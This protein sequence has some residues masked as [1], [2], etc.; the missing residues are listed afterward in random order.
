[1]RWNK[2]G[3]VFGPE[4]VH[5]QGPTV[6]V[7]EKCLRIYFATR[8]RANESI[9]I[10]LDADINDPTKILAVHDSPLLQLGERGSFDEFGIIPCAV[11]PNG[12]EIWMYYTGWSRG[13][14]VT[15]LLSVGLAVSRDEGRTFSKAYPGP[16]LDRTKVEP[17]MTM[18]PFV[19]REGP[20]W[21]MW[22]GS[23]IGFRE[24]EGKYEPQ[25]VI[26]YAGSE[27]GVEWQRPDLT[28]LV[29]KND[30]ESST[31]PTVIKIGDVY[32]MWFAY[33]GAA[34]YRGGQNSYRIGYATS[35]DLLIWHRDDDAAG[36]TVS[37]AGWDSNM[38]TY[39][40]II[41]V[42]GRHLMFYNGNGFGGSGFGYAI[43]SWSQDNGEP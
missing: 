14:T 43:A 38:V 9:P 31:R 3:R 4:G 26:K 22:Y 1:M 18:A 33:R 37:D 13:T 21:H 29:S 15:Y 34:D 17:F 39:P 24:T 2:K 8:P 20:R 6:L 23:G 10:Y 7:T 40:Y 11:V 32:H 12:N 19:L 16:I 28:C 42:A 27:D 36:I 25:Y 30:L 41:E 5:A 35:S